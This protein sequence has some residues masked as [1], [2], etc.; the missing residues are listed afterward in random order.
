MVSS[1]SEVEDCRTSTPAVMLE[2]EYIVIASDDDSC[3]NEKIQSVSA[4]KK[5]SNTSHDELCE[6]VTPSCKGKEDFASIV[7]KQNTPVTD[8]S[9]THSDDELCEQATSSPDGKAEVLSI[10]DTLDKLVNDDTADK[11]DTLINPTGTSLEKVH[12]GSSSSSKVTEKCMGTVTQ[13]QD[14]TLMLMSNTVNLVRKLVSLM[15]PGVCS[16]QTG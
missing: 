7:A 10:V 11:C 8:T 12:A 6:Q 14:E 2:P 5:P 4:P 9:S 15:K 3:N 13:G 1:D 16:A